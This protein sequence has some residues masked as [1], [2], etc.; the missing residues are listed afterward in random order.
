MHHVQPAGGLPARLAHRA[1]VE[2][3]E[4]SLRLTPGQAVKVQGV[5]ISA[6]Y[7]GVSSETTAAWL[8]GSIMSHLGHVKLIHYRI[9]RFVDSWSPQCYTA[10]SSR[11][12]GTR[13]TRRVDGI[14]T[15]ILVASGKT[16]YRERAT[17]STS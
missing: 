3:N 4:R 11:L 10:P 9:L 17:C 2:V 12:G 7:G 1:V 15:L 6:G 8:G 5:W 16:S 13:G 14:Q